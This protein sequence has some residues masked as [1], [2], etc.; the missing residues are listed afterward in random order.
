MI[1]SVALRNTSSSSVCR[2][3][4]SIDASSQ[5]SMTHAQKT[6]KTTLNPLKLQNQSSQVHLEEF[7][8]TPESP[9]CENPQLCDLKV[10]K[11][12]ALL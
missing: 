11:P 8:T 9:V 10:G 5:A 6:S 4:L 12:L 3:T 1:I 7:A 2:A